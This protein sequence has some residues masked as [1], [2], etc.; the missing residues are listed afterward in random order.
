[1]TGAN[2]KGS[3]RGKLFR[4][5]VRSESRALSIQRGVGKYSTFHEGGRSEASRAKNF[6]VAGRSW[7]RRLD[8]SGFIDRAYGAQGLN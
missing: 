5:H 8:E 3:V 2:D 7:V 4:Y 1:V 6:E